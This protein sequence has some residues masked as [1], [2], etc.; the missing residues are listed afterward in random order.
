[1]KTPCIYPAGEESAGIRQANV[2]QVDRIRGAFKETPKCRQR[3]HVDMN[4]NP[5]SAEGKQEKGVSRIQTGTRATFQAQKVGP[6]GILARLNG[7]R[8]RS[9]LMYEITPSAQSMYRYTVTTSPRFAASLQG[10]AH[11]MRAVLTSARPARVKRDS[12]AKQSKDAKHNN[13]LGAGL[14]ELRCREHVEPTSPHQLPPLA[15][16]SSPPLYPRPQCASQRRKASFSRDAAQV[17]TR[18][19]SVATQ[20]V[21]AP[22]RVY[23]SLGLVWGLPASA[24]AHNSTE[25]PVP[26]A[27]LLVSPSSHR[28][29]WG[30]GTANL[31]CEDVGR[32]HICPVLPTACA[33]PGGSV[34]ERLPALSKQRSASQ[35]NRRIFVLC[36][37]QVDECG[38]EQRK[39]LSCKSKRWLESVLW[40][41]RILLERDVRA[42]WR[43]NPRGLLRVTKTSSGTR[44]YTRAIRVSGYRAWYPA[45]GYPGIPHPAHHFA[46]SGSRSIFGASTLQLE[47]AP[48]AN[49]NNGSLPAARIPGEEKSALCEE[50][51]AC[52]HFWPRS[53]GL[54]ASSKSQR[55]DPALRALFRLH[56][57]APARPG[58]KGPWDDERGVR[59]DQQRSPRFPGSILV[60][61]STPALRRA[62]PQSE[63]PLIGDEE[64]A[65]KIS[66]ASW[67]DRSRLGDKEY[68]SG[69]GLRLAVSYASISQSE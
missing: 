23:S 63:S 27:S 8:E 38:G 53:C 36:R 66:W 42:V 16:R 17:A 47:H 65:P 33:S 67:E 35:L 18:I 20:C 43:L 32:G 44:P 28:H 10:G 6:R 54:E 2:F 31:I 21:C 41:A 51:C 62:P 7:P 49:V 34:K 15:P 60:P 56:L 48:V 45:T 61:R 55:A 64:W 14:R 39:K 19:S 52:G 9:A 29:T 37:G 69:R 11:V 46:A 5:A 1:M 50:P 22:W 68:I 30:L 25:S 58:Q 57:A 24:G 13:Q 3:P 26:P 59:D 12:A 4:D 40:R